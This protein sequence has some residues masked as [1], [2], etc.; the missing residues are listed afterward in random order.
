M[1]AR[2]D[3]PPASPP[4]TSFSD[5]HKLA[6][7]FQMLKPSDTSETAKEGMYCRIMLTNAAYSSASY[8]AGSAPGD[9]SAHEVIVECSAAGTEVAQ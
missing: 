8:L 9:M 1:M 3:K 7:A 5:G 4:S 6:T 2:I